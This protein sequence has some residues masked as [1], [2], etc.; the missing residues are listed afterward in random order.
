MNTSTIANIVSREEL[1]AENGLILMIL[2]SE[3]VFGVAGNAFLFYVLASNDIQLNL[4]IKV[5]L[6]LE[7]VYKGVFSLFNGLKA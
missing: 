1:T 3:S 5:L 2:T 6:M 4:L 7:S